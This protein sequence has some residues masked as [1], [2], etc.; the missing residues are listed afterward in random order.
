M[1]E[2]TNWQKVKRFLLSKDFRIKFLCADSSAMNEKEGSTRM[3]FQAGLP[4][5]LGTT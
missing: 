3:I 1:N 5:F 4:N 2:E